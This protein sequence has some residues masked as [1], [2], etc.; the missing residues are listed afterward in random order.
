M[1]PIDGKL[2][3]VE[4][5]AVS[6]RD[7]EK[8][9]HARGCLYPGEDDAG[10]TPLNYAEVIK[11]LTKLYSEEGTQQALHKSNAFIDT[12]KPAHN[13]AGSFNNF[14]CN[15]GEN[16]TSL[17]KLSTYEYKD[18][19]VFSNLLYTNCAGLLIIISCIL[20]IAML[21]ALFLTNLAKIFKN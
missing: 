10:G 19:T 2:F 6:L 4:K 9:L 7:Q 12:L 8:E 18:I 11:A 1:L 14:S 3:D 20:F 15:A 17:K 5:L 16:K 21:G 13:A